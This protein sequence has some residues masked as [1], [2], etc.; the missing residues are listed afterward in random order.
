MLRFTNKN[1]LA[2][3]ASYEVT[4]MLAKRMKPF[5]D[6]ELIKKCMETVVNT[7]FCTFSNF[8]EIRDQISNLQLSDAT[9]VRRIK[10][11]GNQVFDSVINELTDCRFFSLALDSSVDISSTSQ[12]ILFVR[13]CSKDNIIKEDILKVI[14]MKSQTRGVDYFET[15]STVFEKNKIVWQKLISICTDGCPSMVGINSGLVTVIKNTI[16]KR[17]LINFHCIIHQENLSFKFPNDFSVVM[18]KTIK[19]VN[20]IRAR[21]LNH[22]K[23]KEF[24]S[25]LNFQY[26]DIMFHTEVRWLSKGKVLERFFSLREEIKFIH[27]MASKIFAFEENLKMYI[28]EVSKNDFSSF[29]KFELMTKEN[30]NFSDDTD[31]ETL[32]PQL[33]ELLGTLKNEMNN[34]FNDIKN[35][36]NAF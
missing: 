8:K 9:C 16:E 11:L 21:D 29:S 18:N 6:V 23:F 2:T 25:E 4:H 34:R 10:H 26:S 22:R 17:K 27:H 14:P 7:L 13:F 31:I 5:S 30:K 3:K 12:L 1:E 15:I 35:L 24:L 19:I 28:E 33:L 32:K 36:R 20:F